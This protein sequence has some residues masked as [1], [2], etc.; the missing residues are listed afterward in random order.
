MMAED[1][2]SP[3]HAAAQAGHI[4]CLTFLTSLGIHNCMY[5]QVFTFRSIYQAVPFVSV[6]R[7]GQPL[8]ILR[9]PADRY[10]LHITNAL[11]QSPILNPLP[12]PPLLPPSLPLLPSSLPSPPS[13]LPSPPPLLPPLFPSP[14]GGDSGMDPGPRWICSGQRQSGRD[15]SP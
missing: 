2:M 9:L 4:P 8:P 6:L 12:S 3:I 1:G 14:L 13:P 10:I 7:T 5:S 15:S 11:L